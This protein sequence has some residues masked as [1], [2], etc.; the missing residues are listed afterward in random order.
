[1][2][3]EGT[4][5]ATGL[6]F[7]EGPVWRDGSLLVTEIEGGRVSRWRDGTVSP[8]ATTGGGPNGA[9]RGRTAPCT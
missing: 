8:F 6:A 2:T 1:V 4:V 3:S 5:V 7:P 9:A